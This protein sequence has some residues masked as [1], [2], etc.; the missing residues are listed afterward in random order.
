[1]SKIIWPD[2]QATL[3]YQNDITRIYKDSHGYGLKISPITAS[4]PIF[5]LQPLLDVIKTLSHPSILKV[6]D[7]NFR[8]DNE[9]GITYVLILSNYVYGFTLLEAL[10]NKTLSDIE[11]FSICLQIFS[12]INYL[13]LRGI[14]H[15]DIK[16]ENITIVTSKGLTLP[17]ITDL[18]LSCTMAVNCID[19]VGTPSYMDINMIKSKSNPDYVAN[20]W[21]AYAVLIYIIFMG[22]SPYPDVQ[23]LNIIYKLKSQNGHIPTGTIYPDLNHLIN[24]MLDADIKKRPSKN[25]VKDVLINL[26]Q[27]IVSS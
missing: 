20:D 3:I 26:L 17:I 6:L 18:N 23:D 7:Y 16:L 10:K 25:E 24:R 8:I 19:K 2:Y 27:Y 1:M 14:V 15:R 11:K 9:T 12:A 5:K 4:T 13:H 21:Y 22:I